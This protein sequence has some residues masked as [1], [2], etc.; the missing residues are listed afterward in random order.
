MLLDTLINFAID[1]KV[2]NIFLGTMS[3]FK[4][5]QKFYK[6][7]NF[8]IIPQTFLPIDFPINPVD[9]IFYKRELN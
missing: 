2:S 7:H 3:Q 1:S 9:T 5:A 6:K 4:A 8:I